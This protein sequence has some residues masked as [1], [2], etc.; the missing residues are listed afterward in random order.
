M[1]TDEPQVD[2]GPASDRVRLRRGAHNGVYEHEAVLAV[3]DAGLIAHVGVV[4]AD[5]PIV[6]PMA[7]GRSDDEIY[8]HGS[9]AN[10]ALRAADGADVCVTVTVIDGLIVGRSPFHNSMQYRSVVVRGLARRVRDD[11]E[12]VDALRRVSNHVV[13]TWNGA[14]PPTADELRRT[15][16]IAVPLVELSAKVRTG[17]PADEPEDLEGP[18]WGGS[19]PIV[20]TFGDAVPS[21]DLPPGIAVPSPV[22]ALA[23]SAVH[24]PTDGR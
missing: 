15:M 7:Y 19:V 20:A 6:I 2:E 9:V 5:G 3:L 18:H 13:A 17:G 24:A 10:A 16:V 8:L 4:T 22:A 1:S 11:A 14:R 12:H 21:P 23:G